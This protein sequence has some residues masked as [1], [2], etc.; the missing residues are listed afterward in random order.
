MVNILFAFDN[1][2]CKNITN[3][4]LRFWFNWITYIISF[5]FDIFCIVRYDTYVLMYYPVWPGLIA[6][7]FQGFRQNKCSFC[8]AAEYGGR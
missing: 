4:P 6:S 8:K 3:I 2:F 5:T 1:I 7:L